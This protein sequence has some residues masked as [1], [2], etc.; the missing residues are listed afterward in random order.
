MVAEITSDKHSMCIASPALLPVASAV[1]ALSLCLSCGANHYGGEGA[2]SNITHS[3][4]FSGNL[5]IYGIPYFSHKENDDINTFFDAVE[6][7]FLREGT[8]QL[9][10]QVGR[11]TYKQ[12]DIIIKKNDTVKFT[13]FNGQENLFTGKA[14]YVQLRGEN[15]KD[16]YFAR[17]EPVT[18]IITHFD[19]L[20]G[21]KI[22]DR[23]AIN[24]IP[25]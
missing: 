16:I 1:L 10:V 14:K 9:A 18:L 25:R 23:I 11:F 5:A 4:L 7:K 3:E 6:L 13:P 17:D 12:E 2:S 20:V 8:Y 19:K 22:T 24:E 21:S 15:G